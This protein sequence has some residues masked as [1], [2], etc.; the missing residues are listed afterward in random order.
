MGRWL[1]GL[2]ALQRPTRLLPIPVRQG[3]GVLR[4]RPP[5]SPGTV[6]GHGRRLLDFEGPPALPSARCRK[7]GSRLSSAQSPA[8]AW[9]R[10]AMS[11]CAHVTCFA[12][13][14]N[15]TALG[16]LSALKPAPT[17]RT[18]RTNRIQPTTT[19]HWLRDVPWIASVHRDLVKRHH[20]SRGILGVVGPCLSHT[21][22]V[23]M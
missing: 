8:T 15:A 23:H 4:R 11:P 5:C 19:T 6:R 18:G 20:S 1:H 9:A 22:M 17:A 12:A 14:S 10:I 21:E 2:R 7:V 3:R 16:S 13:T